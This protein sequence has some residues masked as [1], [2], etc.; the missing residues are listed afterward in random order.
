MYNDKWKFAIV[1]YIC[2]VFFSHRWAQCLMLLKQNLIIYE[3]LY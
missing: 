3:N 2:I 1:Y